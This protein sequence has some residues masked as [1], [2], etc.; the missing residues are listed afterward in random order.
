[1]IAAAREA[2]L[3]CCGLVPQGR[4]LLALGILNRLR[5][6]STEFSWEEYQE[7]KAIEDLFLPAGMG[8]SHQVLILATQGV[9]RDLACLRP[10]EEWE[11]PGG[12]RH[13]RIGGTRE[14]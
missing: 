6:A 10:P 2:G 7:R 9:E 4:F 8:E 3:A 14:G 1:M 11:T 5:P 13:E 12:E